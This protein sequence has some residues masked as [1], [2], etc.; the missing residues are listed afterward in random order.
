MFGAV[1][2]ALQQHE[3]LQAR[4]TKLEQEN[5]QLREDLQAARAELEFLRSERLDA[6]EALKAIAVQ[7]TRLATAA[8]QR[9]SKP[10]G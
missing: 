1:V 5:Q 10:V 2:G 3:P 8:L 7:V 9:L 6:A 4:V